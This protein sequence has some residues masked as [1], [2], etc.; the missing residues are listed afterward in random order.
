M[1]FERLSLR[2]DLLL[3]H[4]RCCE[5]VDISPELDDFPEKVLRLAL[6]VCHC[7]CSIGVAGGEL[8]DSQ[9]LVHVGKCSLLTAMSRGALSSLW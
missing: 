9:H 8:V 4:L 2:I 5:R 7:S 6:P 3:L 1:F